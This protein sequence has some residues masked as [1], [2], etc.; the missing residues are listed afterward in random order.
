MKYFNKDIH[1]KNDFEISKNLDWKQFYL[2]IKII[3]Q[4][5]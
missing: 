2:I 1:G 5:V 3:K 4:K